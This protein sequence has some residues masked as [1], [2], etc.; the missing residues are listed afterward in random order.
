MFLGV[1]SMADE[2]FIL[3]DVM[4]ID[5]ADAN[6]HLVPCQR[7]Q[8]K[9]QIAEIR[10]H[11]VITWGL[12]VIRRRTF[13]RGSARSL[14]DERLSIGQHRS[15]GPARCEFSLQRLGKL[16]QGCLCVGHVHGEIV[17]GRR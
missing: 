12:G 1:D 13:V 14:R 3:S 15:D 4:A 10:D 7:R 16:V 6:A 11:F 9:I 5:A 17:S 2:L 8:Q